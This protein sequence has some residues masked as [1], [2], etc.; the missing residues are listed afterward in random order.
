MTK[1][2]L[3][4]H[5]KSLSD[6]QIKA[7]MRF[8]DNKEL[9]KSVWSE[10]YPSLPLLNVGEAA[11]C[12][13]YGASPIC[14]TSNHR[15]FKQFPKGYYNVCDLGMAKCDCYLSERKSLSLKASR[16]M[17]EDDRATRVEKYKK[18]M[19][20]RYG[21]ENGFQHPAIKE[22]SRQTIKD[23]Y[24]VESVHQI[25][26]VPEK[27]VEN[28][29]AKWGTD[30]PR[31][32][33]A[34]NQ[35]IK[36]T[37]LKRYG[38]YYAIRTPDVLEKAHASMLKKYG[39]TNYFS[40]PDH[41]KKI[42]DALY[43][44]TGCT[45]Q[46]QL[47]L[48]EGVLAILTNEEEFTKLC[49]GNN[50]E[51]VAA[52]LG[53]SAFTVARYA[54]LYDI[55]DQMSLGYGSAQEKLLADTIRNM[56]VAVVERS[57]QL[58]PPYEVDIYLPE[59]KMA[60]EYNGIYHHTEFTGKKDK[61][62]HLKKYELCRDRGIDLIQVCS[63]VYQ[64]KKDVILSMI[65]GKLGMSSRIP[66]RKCIL[67]EVSYRDAVEFLD[68]THLMTSTTTGSIRLGL[69]YCDELVQIL[70][71]GNSRK[72]M[73][74]KSTVGEYEII[75]IASKLDT[76]VVGGLSKLFTYFV[77]EYA[78][79]R[80]FSYSDLRYFTGKSLKQLG[81]RDVGVSK[82]GYWYTDYVNVFHRYNFRKDE[83]VRKGHDPSFTE[84]EIM[85]GLGYDRLWDCGQQKWEWTVDEYKN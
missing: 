51:Y 45:N 3:I 63:T 73:S 38:D 40:V 15:K 84:S 18:T 62:Y 14:S 17:T 21:V 65:K 81:F 58:I 6:E 33:E 7:W 76:V 83:L 61:Y 68:K 74:G 77:T 67:R 39:V 42:R 25:P 54:R 46:G 27:R 11:Y 43:E 47:K 10:V 69:Y 30:H 13:K 57:R 34:V 31:Q 8:S 2:E 28:S 66:A 72:A 5:L 19:I 29:R 64:K 20:E 41:Q 48:S 26:G 37:N 12:F 9:L 36:D 49:I 70:T 56:G 22:K 78:P 35:R 55:V 32:S 60:I 50:F 59:Y 53:T 16:N 24:G 4:S 82:V 75:R 23:R 44:Q 52:S 79:S 71:L 80:V 85:R 1:D